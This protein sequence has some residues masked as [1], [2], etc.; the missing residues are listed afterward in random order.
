MCLHCG[1]RISWR[2]NLPVVSYLLLRGKCRH[3][4]ET[5]S[6]RY[7]FVELLGGLLAVLVLRKF[8][9]TPPAAVYYLFAGC[10]LVITFIDLDHRIIPDVIS[11]PGRPVFFFAT[12]LVPWMSIKDSILGILAGGGSLFLVA[13]IY[14]RITRKEGM[15]GGDVKLLA[16]IGA[17][18][19]WRG[20]LFTIFVASSVGTIIGVMVMLIT[21]KNMKLALPFAP[22]LA[23]GALAYIFFGA[24]LIEWYSHILR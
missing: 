5:I 6:L 15:G 9:A 17:L 16:M 20:V 11:L 24:E 4:R 13:W 21:H 14:H 1:R 22:F 8:G 23:L 3:C 19:G 7:P 12:L 2:D 10:L 18:V